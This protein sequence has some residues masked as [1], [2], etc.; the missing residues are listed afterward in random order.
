M[1]TISYKNGFIHGNCASAYCEAQL[2]DFRILG[3]FKGIKAAKAAIT[4]YLNSQK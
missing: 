4:K 3:Q 2:G 1:W